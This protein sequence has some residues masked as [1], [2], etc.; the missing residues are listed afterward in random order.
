MRDLSLACLAGELPKEFADLHPHRRGDRIADAEEAA[1]WADR[2]L[3]VPL[4]HALPRQDRCFAFVREEQ[5]FEVVQLLVVER[6]VRLCEVNLS[7]G[8]VDLR[9]SVC[10]LGRPRDVLWKDETPS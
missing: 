7:P 6:I 8:L 3:P 1:G 4:G 9:H 5:S 2:H 10:M